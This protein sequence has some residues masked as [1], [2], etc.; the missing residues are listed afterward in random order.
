M[1]NLDKKFL[2]L[3]IERKLFTAKQLEDVNNDSLLESEDL[4]E[5]LL[6]KGVIDNEKLTEVKAEAANMA[7][8]NLADMDVTEQTL[9]VISFDLAET[10]NVV[11]FEKNKSEASFGVVDPYNF[12]A[13]EAIN[14]LAYKKKW[15]AKFFLISKENFDRIFRQYQNLKKEISTALEIKT[16]ESGGDSGELVSLSDDD[17]IVGDDNDIHSA[18]VAKMV[19]VIIRHAVDGSASDIHIEPMENETRVRYRIDGILSTTLLL[20]RKVHSAIVGRLK[21][22]AKLKLD[23]TRVP[24]DGRIRL[25]IGDDKID[26]RVSSIPL[27]RGEKIVL[28]VLNLGKKIPTLEDLGFTGRNL[29]V[30]QENIKKTFGLLLLTG[31][32]GCGK[33]TTLASV[34]DILNKEDI[35]I[36]TL[37]DPIEYFL[38]GINQSQI[39]P[40]IGYT[41]STGLR[42][43]LRQDPD[44]LMVGEIR[45][46]ETAELCI[47]AGLTGHLVLT[48]LHTN[49]ALDAVPR[50]TDMGID[51]FLLGSTLHTVVAQRLSRKICKKCK[52]EYELPEKM[53]E[54]IQDELKKIPIS[55][56]KAILGDEFDLNNLT[57]YKGT[58][59][60]YC[61][62]TGYKG[63]VALVEVLD[64]KDDIKESIMNKKRRLSVDDVQKGQVFTTMKQDGIIKALQGITSIEEVLRVIE[65]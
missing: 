14:F 33:S 26:F 35:N 28:R 18:P 23:E 16:G 36:S 13:I 41:F 64:L 17:G 50:L 55:S 19:S 27:I 11:C 60:N 31:P 30:I 21:V 22:L 24:Q 1:N 8:T 6:N 5:F 20:P 59:C 29:E 7:Y 12:K 4:Q 65:D 51:S 32:T 9:N 53:K 37:E 34:L 39:R 42:S 25:L 57:F 61:G 52:K 46:A 40:A 58:G 62:N 47:Q 43:L 56:L 15:N 54:K 44:I 48:T 3:L 63:R 38:K 49:G 45:D 2:D 10:Y